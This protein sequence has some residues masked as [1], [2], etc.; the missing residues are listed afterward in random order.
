ML[1][2]AYNSRDTD[3]T[4]T[5]RDANRNPITLAVG[6]KIRVKVGRSS[7]ETP[8]LDI[9]SGSPLS[10]GTQINAVNPATLK[11]YK[12]DLAIANIK[13]GIYD[14]EVSVVDSAD[15]SRIKHAESAIFQVIG[16]QLG[17]VN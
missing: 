12:A 2:T 4:V 13:P 6:D 11:L 9:V 14:C 3:E 1:I 16:T 5:L 10:G 8:L 15:S 7:N 17:G